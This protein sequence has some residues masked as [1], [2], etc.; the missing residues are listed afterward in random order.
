M[1]VTCEAPD[2]SVISLTWFLTRFSRGLIS[3]AVFRAWKTKELASK[4]TFPSGDLCTFRKVNRSG[5]NDK[6]G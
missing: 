4:Q 5:L 3:S 6:S 1:F 2:E